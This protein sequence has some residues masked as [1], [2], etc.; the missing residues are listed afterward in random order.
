MKDRVTYASQ[1]LYVGPSGVN[2]SLGETAISGVVPTQL[3][4]IKYIEHSME[5]ENEHV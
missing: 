2:G 1:I 3:H 5:T 4:H